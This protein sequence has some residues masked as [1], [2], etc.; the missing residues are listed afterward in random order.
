LDHREIKEFLV[1]I[2]VPLNAESGTHTAIIIFP[3]I[4]EVKTSGDNAAT[5][6]DQVGVP[7]FITVKGDVKFDA[8]IKSIETRDMNKNPT[9]N[10]YTQNVYIHTVIQNDS[11]IYVRPFG[12]IFI[13]QGDKTKPVGTIEFTPGIYNIVSS[14]SSR[15]FVHTFEVNGFINDGESNWFSLNKYRFDKFFDFKFGTFY[16]TYQ[17]RIRASDESNIDKKD[18][19]IVTEKTTKFFVFPVQLFLII[20]VLIIILAIIG[21]KVYK[22]RKNKSSVMKIR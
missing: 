6:L 20:P 8:Q 15:E 21:Y 22:H 16:A 2:D 10:F 4:Q 3:R 13:H 5:L 1:E 9:S 11:N 7:V 18:G 14:N 12:N 17:A 19:I